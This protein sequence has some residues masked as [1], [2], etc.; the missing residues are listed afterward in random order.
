MAAR[1]D[2]GE[3]P[4]DEDAGVRRRLVAVGDAEA[5]ADVDVREP[6]G[7]VGLD[8]LDQI[9]QAVERIDVRS[10]V[11]D[12]RADVAVD[13]DDLDPGQ[14]RR[15]RERG[16]RV[17]VGDAELVGAQPG[18]DVGMR[19]RVDVGIDAQ[20][21]ARAPA[22][23]ARDL[24]QQLELAD[25]L[26]V[27]AEDVERERALHLGARLAD[28]REDDP[29]RR[30]AGGEDALELAARDDVEAAA[31]AREPLQ[32]GER[33][34]GLDGIAEQM[35]ASGE[36]TLVGGEG[37]RHRRAR[38]DVERR[39]E[40]ARQLGGGDALD[41]ERAVAAGD[42]GSAG[43]VHQRG[44]DAGVVSGAANDGSGDRSGTAAGGTGLTPISGPF[45]PHDASK[46]KAIVAS[47]RA[48]VATTLPARFLMA[49]LSTVNTT[50][51][52]DELS[53][54]EY[55]RR[56][57]AVLAAVEAAADRLLQDDVIDIDA[58]RTGGLL[59]LAFPNGSKIVINTQ[60]PLHE[61]WLAAR[62]RRLSLPIAR[63]ALDRRPRRARVLRSPVGV[64]KRAGRPPAALRS[65]TLG[66][67]RRNRSR[68]L[69]LSSSLGGV[70]AAL[71][72]RPRLLTPAPRAYSS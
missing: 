53:D 9:E 1:V 42:L 43:Q 54:V 13:A 45:C 15:A 67:Q 14:L 12:L 34:V 61:L 52:P 20:A 22:R 44:A 2:V 3:Q 11:D 6:D 18:R 30:A 56:T 62:R 19:L 39:A 16:A 38:I 8:R 24:A 60:P 28:A 57:R 10:C 37:A 58:S 26:D 33:R 66:A 4:R 51:S 50:P 55:D 17:A 48:A 71:S 40:A 65:R 27:E 64:R 36:R 70:G 7:A 5:A 29:L 72:S 35:V 32:D 47:E 49:R 68:M 21:D 69:F 25:A 31:A 23:S 63:R 41:E 59:E 46:A